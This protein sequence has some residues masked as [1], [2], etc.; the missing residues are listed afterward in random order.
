MELCSG[1]VVQETFENRPIYNQY[2][3]T[4][5][6]DINTFYPVVFPERLEYLNTI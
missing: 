4:V 2:T 1:A 5:D 3:L 6:G